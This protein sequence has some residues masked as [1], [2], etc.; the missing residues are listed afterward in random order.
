MRKT[1]MHDLFERI[2]I[3]S[4]DFVIKDSTIYSWMYTG[5][6]SFPRKGPVLR[7]EPPKGKFKKKTL[8]GRGQTGEW[9][10]STVITIA[11]F[12]SLRN[13]QHGDI[14]PLSLDRIGLVL[15]LVDYIH[16][17]TTVMFPLDWGV[18]NFRRLEYSDFYYKTDRFLVSEELHSYII[19]CI[20]T[21]QKVLNKIHVSNPVRE[22]LTWKEEH[23]GRSCESEAE[24]THYRLDSVALDQSVKIDSVEMRVVPLRKRTNETERSETKEWQL[25][26]SS[27]VFYY[28]SSPFVLRY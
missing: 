13:P 18:P 27:L 21:R 8:F 11:E 25:S 3:E 16:S 7:G 6:V 22:I 19:R 28:G 5:F 26:Y 20:C 14:E 10:P 1:E 4:K 12:W 24:E 23:S 2:G 9:D 15:E 17:P